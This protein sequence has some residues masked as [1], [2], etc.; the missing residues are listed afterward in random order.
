MYF[1]NH[2]SY[3]VCRVNFQFENRSN[4]EKPENS[5][6]LRSKKTTKINDLYFDSNT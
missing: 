2:K 6:R 4:P 3:N 5:N 1:E